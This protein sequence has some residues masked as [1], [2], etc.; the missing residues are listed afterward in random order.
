MKHHFSKR[1]IRKTIAEKLVVASLI[2]SVFVFISYS[3]GYEEVLWYPIPFIIFIFGVLSMGTYKNQHRLLTTH[4][5]EVDSGKIVI[6]QY[7]RSLSLDLSA[8]DSLDIRPRKKTPNRIIGKMGKTQLF[9]L[10]GYEQMDVL[11][12]E[13]QGQ[14]N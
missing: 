6:N 9:D 10:K 11:V 3:R 7:P 12:T 1:H 4:E 2:S 5:L 13:I 8:V 14:L